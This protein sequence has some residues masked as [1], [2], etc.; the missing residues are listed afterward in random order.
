[1]QPFNYKNNILGLIGGMGPLTSAQFIKTIY[2]LAK[3]DE[4]ASMPKLHLVSEPNVPD[5]TKSLMQ[6]DTSLLASRI[7]EL[8]KLIEP[9]V[10]KILICCFTAHAVR[11]QLYPQAQ[12]KLIDLVDY[13]V[14][15]MKQLETPTLFIASQGVYR[16]KLFPLEKYPFVCL[17][18]DTDRDEVH[19]QIYN[20]LKMGVGY[21]Q[22]HDYFEVLLNKYNCT[23]IFGGCT[24]IH[25]L[26]MW[27]ENRL[28]ILDPLYEIAK[29][30]TSA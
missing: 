29:E 15:L 28:N 6:G 10:D 7:N 22:V 20:R 11:Y 13:S 3:E 17:L 19:H 5:R 1:M 14:N 4:E 12:N 26:K 27:T 8:L 16:T 23:Q 18:D 2:Q 24:E 9:N 25:L 30:F 21:D